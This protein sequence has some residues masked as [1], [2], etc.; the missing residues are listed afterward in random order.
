MSPLRLR[1]FAGP[2]GSGKSTFISQF[3]LN[4]K[5]H[6]GEYVNA[7]VIEAALYKFRTYKLS[8]ISLSTYEVQEY[9]KH[10]QFSPIKIDNLDL[11]KSF[12]IDNNS[13]KISNDLVMNSY[14]AADL[15]EFLR[16]KYLELRLSFSFE[17][18]LSDARK[19]DFLRE[20]KQFG[21]RIYLYYFC[22]IDPEI[23][24]NRVK[25]RIAQAG[26]SVSEDL[27]IKRYYKSLENLKPTTLISD[28]AFLF[29]SS[30]N[31][32][33]LIA[34]VQDGEEV[35]IKQ[36]ESIPNWFIKYLM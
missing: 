23:N 10:S 33:Q 15:A 9:F 20:A 34:E 12:Y 16:R 14:I 19:I 4:G 30:E 17:T 8:N 28:R 24:I 22:T 31:I 2:N 18:V 27:I 35:E 1:V 13:I 25:I 29:D 7:D 6:L 36:M 11:W 5:V 32:N 26:H 21:Y 3:P